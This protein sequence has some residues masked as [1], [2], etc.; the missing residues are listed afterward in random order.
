MKRALVALAMLSAVA[1]PSL[2]E[3]RRRVAVLEFRAGVEQVQNLGGRIAER[4]KKTTALTVVDPQEARRRSAAIDA[5]VARCAGDAPCVAKVG[6]S[7]EVDEVLLLGVSKVGDVVLAL[8]RIDVET[9]AVTGQL[10]EVLPSAEEVEDK[11][12][13]GWLRQLYPPEVFKR[14]GFI[15][16]TANVDGATVTIN[17]Q[18]RGE[19]PLEGKLKVLAPRSYRVELA[20]PDYSPFA[21]RIDVPPDATVEVRAEMTRAAGLLPWYK[22]WYLWA[23]VGGVAVGAAVGVAVYS[24]QPDST[25]VMGFIQR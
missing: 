23:I 20:K 18:P 12:I 1:R 5:A 4:L 22:R 14:Y 9:Q 19:T 15:V 21:A 11:K 2:A 10:S 6:T 24:L 25:N 16:V 8:Q 13:L 7:L 17:N 3:E